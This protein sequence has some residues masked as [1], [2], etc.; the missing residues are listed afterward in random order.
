MAGP[1][2]VVPA[3]ADDAAAALVFHAGIMPPADSYRLTAMRGLTPCLKEG[4][5]AALLVK[6]IR[7]GRNIFLTGEGGTGKSVA[8]R[9]AVTILRH[10]DRKVI[11]CAPTGIAA[12]EIGGTTIHSAFRFDF[13]PKVAD[14]LEAVQ[15]SKVVH[16]ADAIIIDEIGM[17]R[18]DAHG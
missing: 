14:A 15:P 13:A 16:E 6:A 5:C 4:A 12:Q 2:L 3:A 11:L 10:D 18:D 1:S 9:E 7:S 8:I 17:V